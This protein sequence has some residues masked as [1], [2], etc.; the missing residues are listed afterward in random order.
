VKRRRSGEFTAILPLKN[1]ARK[2]SAKIL[3]KSIDPFC[4][5]DMFILHPKTGEMVQLRL[6]FCLP[7]CWK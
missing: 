4:G 7:R 3:Q 5:F 2:K 6:Q 1:R